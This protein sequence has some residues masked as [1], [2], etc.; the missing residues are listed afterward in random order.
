MTYGLSMK[1]SR[2][3]QKITTLF[4]AG[5]NLFNNDVL[6]N[7]LEVQTGLLC[8]CLKYSDL[9]DLLQND[10]TT[11]TFIVFLDYSTLGSVNPCGSTPE[12]PYQPNRRFKAIWFNVDPND[13]LEYDALRQGICGILYDHQPVD[14]YIRAVHA[15]L[16]GELFYPRRILE[17]LVMTDDLSVPVAPQPDV[18]V[19]LTRREKEIFEIMASG[20]PNSEIAAKLCLSPHTVKTH[21][22]NL[23]KKIKV[24]NRYQAAQW[25][26]EQS[27]RL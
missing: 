7:F 16:N 20:V 9:S 1:R 14:L 22:Y 17:V 3:Q 21:I 24:N 11:K 19:I 10:D 8:R 2:G 18:D 4:V 15:V 26:R 25:L 6:S 12:S 5:N 23:Y 27:G 13:R